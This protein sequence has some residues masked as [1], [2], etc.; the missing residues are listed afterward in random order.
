VT[1]SPRMDDW[2]SRAADALAEASGVTRESL[3]L[4]AATE[5]TLLDLARVAAHGSGARTNAP[6]LA[7][8]V[9]RTGLDPARAAELLPEERP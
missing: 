6:L 8:L 5:A 9:G 2:L 1:E 7:Y 4:D 3:E